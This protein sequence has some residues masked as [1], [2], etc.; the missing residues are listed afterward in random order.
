[1]ST[2][3][4]LFGG[5]GDKTAP[6]ETA[7]QTYEGFRIYLEPAHEGRRR[8]IDARVG[9]EVGRRLP[10]TRERIPLRKP[11]SFLDQ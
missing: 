2:L 10:V 9:S 3:S 11:P 6:K 4:G 5:G 7:P 1:M 8:R